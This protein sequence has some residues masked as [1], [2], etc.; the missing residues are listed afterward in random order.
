MTLIRL[1]TG[2]TILTDI[3]IRGSADNPNDPTPDVAT[4]LR[5][6]LK[7]DG[8]GRLY[9]DAF[10]LTHP[11]EDHIRGLMNHFHLGPPS[12]WSKSADKILIL[13]M[14][15]SPIV[16]RRADKKNH[17]LCDDAKAWAKEARRRVQSFKDSGNASDGDRVKILGE[18]VDGK[19]DGLRAILVKL[20][21]TFET[22]CGVVD[23]SFVARLL[24]PRRPAVD[25]TEEEVL[26]KN[27]SS[28]ILHLSLKVAG[29]VRARYLIGGDAE[30]AIWERIWDHHKNTPERLQYDVL[31]APHHCSWHSLSWDSW[32]DYGEDAK[33]SPRA[34][35]ALGQ[36]L[37]G[38]FVI[39][40]SKAI[41]DD[42]DDP[43]CIRAKREYLAIVREAGGKFICLGEGSATEPLI[44]TIGEPKKPDKLLKPATAATGAFS[45]GSSPASSR[46]IMI[47]S[48]PTR[49]S[50]PSGATGLPTDF[51]SPTTLT[52]NFSS[53][54][55]GSA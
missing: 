35:K 49:P 27:N 42:K 37:S 15:S 51:L 50:Q 16:F 36:A 47:S 9:V 46:P 4:Q 19:T 20:E 55:M 38:A 13:E 30:V 5:K 8:K 33:L 22:I 21:E 34:R 41:K 44:L 12:A 14:W 26:T 48:S 31:I 54:L 53:R 39:A 29:A 2:R 18:D 25:E 28:V 32:S 23:G 24:A 17:N 52:G 3:N 43:P 1:E 10:L 40:S 6:L 45:K 11:D 7:R